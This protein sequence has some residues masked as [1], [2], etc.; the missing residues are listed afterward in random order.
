V[1]RYINTH[2]PKA[3][4]AIV[5]DSNVNKAHGDAL[6]HALN[7]AHITIEIPAGETSKSFAMLE[8]V[9]DKLLEAKCERGDVLLAIGGG[10]VGDLAGFAA[11]I[12]KRGMNF[13]QIP[14]SLLAQVD[15]SVGG[16]TGI[17]TKRGKNLVGAFMQPKAV[18]ID[19]TMLKTLPPREFKAGYAEVVK[20]G[21][22]NDKAFFEWLE[23]NHT[24]VFS[25]SE[26]GKA[27]LIHAI[28]TACQAKADIVSRD[29]TEQG[30]RALLNLGHTF[31]HAL[32]A[33]C[34]YNPAR[35][36]HGEAVSIGMVLAFRFSSKLG[37]CDVS[38]A[39]RV[40]AHLKTTGLPTK[41]RDIKGLGTPEELLSA[42]MQ[43]K[44]VSRG[45]LN[46]ILATGIGESFIAKNIDC[47]K[48]LAFLHE[49]ATR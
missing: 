13:V 45:Q 17:N 8:F 21:L 31:G 1:S 24:A 18:F 37:L 12:M 16:K 36:I 34:Q 33:D 44:K 32:E 11:S 30:E 25:M 5:T 42:M 41:L 38:V 40:E 35:I 47:D 46:L 10:V 23:T 4:V 28:S 19:I 6:R 48:V 15:S 26:N 29:E 14:T 49:E 9:V 27:A 2:F 20:Y 7:N 22:I 3:R 43:D 39:N